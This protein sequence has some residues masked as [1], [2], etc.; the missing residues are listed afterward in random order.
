[1][2]PTGTPGVVETKM[3]Q[4]GRDGIDEGNNG[5]GL[6]NNSGE[7]IEGE[8]ERINQLRSRFGEA[9][10]PYASALEST[11]QSTVRKRKGINK[12]KTLTTI[13]KESKEIMNNHGRKKTYKDHCKKTKKK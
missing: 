3:L 10:M 13:T 11:S 9:F 6:A 4:T 7:N 2:I 5:N 12:P 8:R 1:M